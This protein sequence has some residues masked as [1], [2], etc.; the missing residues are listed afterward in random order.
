MLKLKKIRAGLYQTLDGRFLIE[1]DGYEPMRSEEQEARIQSGDRRYTGGSTFSEGSSVYSSGTGST[2]YYAP[3]E[4]CWI[5][6]QDGSEDH[7]GNLFDT[8]REAR[9]HIE[10]VYRDEERAKAASASASLIAMQ[11]GTFKAG[12]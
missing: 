1:N 6:F 4:A 11:S 10:R 2:T 12:E 8:L 7:H 3:E 5:V 9:A